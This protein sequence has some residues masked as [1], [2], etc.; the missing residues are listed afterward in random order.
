MRSPQTC[1]SPVKPR[2]DQRAV[3]GDFGITVRC[4]TN[5]VDS[6]PEPAE[7]EIVIVRRPT[8]RAAELT[9]TVT[10]FPR[11]RAVA[12]VLLT[13]T[14]FLPTLFRIRVVTSI[15]PVGCCLP[16]FGVRVNLYEAI[17]PSV[18]LFGGAFTIRATTIFGAT[19]GAFTIADGRTETCDGAGLDGFVVGGGAVVVGGGAVVVGGA[20][21][22]GA[23]SPLSEA[24]TAYGGVEE[25]VT[26][27]CAL[28]V[29]ETVGVPTICPEFGAIESPDGSPVADQLNPGVPPLNDTVV[30]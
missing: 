16:D 2:R 10:D 25:S 22:A 23:M 8:P 9:R 6:K 4:S 1:S 21:G 20:A 11:T 28:K 26:V 19:F 27:T 15:N 13:V 14:V 24:S 29:P 18:T 5:E 7:Y 3:A 17:A 30:A 12:S